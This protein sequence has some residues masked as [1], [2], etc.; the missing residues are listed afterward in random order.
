M[1]LI[2]GKKIADGI[3]AGLD[4]KIKNLARHKIQPKMVTVLVGDDPASIVYVNNKIAM[5]RKL[6]L[7][8]EIIRMPK[9][10][11]TAKV[12]QVVQKICADKK[13][14]G[15]LVQ[16]PLPKQINTPEVL[17]TLS[18]EKD[19]DGFHAYNL[20]KLVVGFEDLPPATPAGIISLLDYKKTKLEGKDIVIVGAS[21]VVGKTLAIMLINRGATVTICNDK[22]KNLA[23]IT[24]RADILISATGVAKIIKARYVKKGA[25]VIDVGFSRDKKG[26]LCGDVDLNSVKKKVG[27]LTP[28]PGGVGLMTIATL[29][30]N[31]LHATER[32]HGLAK[33]YGNI[34]E[35]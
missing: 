22:T 26:K 6:G 11:T 13:V 27:Y 33:T 29:L 7:G 10:S 5:A 17:R 31:L 30:K 35:K 24:S 12:V 1:K 19:I 28:V 20:G 15:V 8:A 25:F 4:K 3:Y 16:L 32:Q 14:N 21:I 23:H 18:P 2:Y 34:S 9:N